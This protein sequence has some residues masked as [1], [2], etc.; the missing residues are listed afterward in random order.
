[1]KQTFTKLCSIGLLLFSVTMAY[2][3]VT[4]GS[5]EA[6]AKGAL[7]QLKDGTKDATNPLLNAKAGLKLPRVHLIDLNNLYPMFE[8]NGAEYKIGTTTYSKATEDETH[9]GLL[10][11]NKNKCVD[12]GQQGLYVWD[13]T[14]WQLVG[15]ERKAFTPTLSQTYFDLPSGLDARPLT[16]QN[17]IITW[18]DTSSVSWTTAADSW[19]P[20][21][22]LATPDSIGT[23]GTSPYTMSILPIAMN[24]T[25]GGSSPW[26]SKQTRLTF[27]N[28][29]TDCGQQNYI[30]LNQT[31]YALRVSN[32]FNSN[33]ITYTTLS[34]K[35]FTVLGN[36]SWTTSLS[37]PYGILTTA[38]TPAIGSN[39]GADMKNSPYTEKTDF[40]Y[41]PNAGKKYDKADIIFSDIDKVKRF[42]DI[43]ISIINCGDSEPSMSEWAARAGFPGVANIKINS[44]DDM[45]KGINTPNGKGVAWHRDQDD[46]IFFSADFGVAGRW[47]ITN[48][49]AKTYASDIDSP[50][51]LIE[52]YSNKNKVANYAYPNI[53]GSTNADDAS[54]YNA[55]RRLGRLYNWF[56]ATANKNT[57]STNQANTAHSQYQGICPSG[58]YL[59]SLLEWTQLTNVL[60]A[61]ANNYSINADREPQISYTIQD[62][63]ETCHSGIGRSLLMSE[64]GFSVL[65]AGY[66]HNGSSAASMNV[67][68]YFWSASSQ[69]T[70]TAWS[71]TF[72]NFANSSGRAF[73][74]KSQMLSVR[75]KQ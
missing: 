20:A 9:T 56:A 54:L 23:L 68:Y 67:S 72:Y 18:S 51:A 32:Q 52:S 50:P 59:P 40:Q 55:N 27:T 64:G 31:N 45:A 74:N 4:I 70:S 49:A 61:D 71:P 30:T 26:R 60:K 6:P 39:N 1:M 11:Y 34:H 15:G 46:N 53:S 66:S 36:V 48:L 2:S 41:T 14:Q 57:S 65:C 44:A 58:W 19:V 63:C 28:L 73:K 3:Q 42:H 7:L 33:F 12:G 29:T 17:L 10:V 69:N 22:D 35:T 25:D 47:M 37:D 38:T 24:S 8:A 5:S 16:A 43:T 75:C 13:G 21:V 62:V